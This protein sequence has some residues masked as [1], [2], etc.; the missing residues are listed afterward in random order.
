MIVEVADASNGCDTAVLLPSTVTVRLFVC[1]FVCP[2]LICSC[3]F[4]IL[5][6][7]TLYVSASSCSRAAATSIRTGN[8][9]P[10]LQ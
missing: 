9:G 7:V 2:H 1:P 6:L 8:V 4:A 5:T 3:S 10:S